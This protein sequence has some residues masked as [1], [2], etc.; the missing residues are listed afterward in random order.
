MGW[1]DLPRFVLH[2]E[3]IRIPMKELR[4]VV[5]VCESMLYALNNPF[6]RCET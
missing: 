5:V 2:V 1:G 3:T 6:R 4:Q